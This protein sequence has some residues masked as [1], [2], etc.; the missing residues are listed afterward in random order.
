MQNEKSPLTFT[1]LPV[2]HAESVLESA[3]S[4]RTL[5]VHHSKQQAGYVAPLNRLVAVM[6][7]AGMSLENIIAHARAT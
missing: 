5:G 6:F 7:C 2:S 4:A 3:F 1:M